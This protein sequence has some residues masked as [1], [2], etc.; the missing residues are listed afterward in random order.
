MIGD[1]V[2]FIKNKKYDNIFYS[3][4]LFEN[5]NILELLYIFI[6]N[7]STKFNE[8]IKEHIKGKGFINYIINRQLQYKVSSEFLKLKDENSVIGNY[9]VCKSISIDHNL[10]NKIET[11]NALDKFKDIYI[12]YN[13][14][15]SNLF[16]LKD[17][18]ITI[19]NINEIDQ[20]N[21]I[22][23]LIVEAELLIHYKELLLFKQIETLL[24]I[25]NKEQYDLHEKHL[26]EQLLNYH[27]FKSIS[28]DIKHNFFILKQK[29]INSYLNKTTLSFICEDLLLKINNDEDYKK[30]LNKKEKFLFFINNNEYFVYNPKHQKLYNALLLENNNYEFILKEYEF[31]T[32]FK[33]IILI[34]K[35][36]YKMEKSRKDSIKKKIFLNDGLNISKYYLIN[37]NW[38]KAYKNLFEYDSIIEY[39]EINEKTLL[40]L[41]KNKDYTNY[42]KNPK[43]LSPDYD[44]NY[45]DTMN[46]PINFELV[47]KDIFESIIEDINKRNK[48]NLKSNLYYNVMLG[49]NKIFVQDNFNETLFFI[50]SL[51]SDKYDLEYII[52]L[53]NRNLFNFINDNND[54]QSFEELLS[55]YGIDLTEKNQQ[56]L[57]DENLKEIGILINIKPKKSNALRGPSHCL[58]LE[59]IGA[60]CYMNATIQCLCHI[61]NMKNYFQNRKLVFNDINNKKCPLTKEFYKLIN[62]LWKYSFNGRKYFTPTNFKNIISQLNP[63]FEG[64]A[65]N[66]SKDLIIFIY[67]TMHNEINRQI[68]FEEVNSYNIDKD[69]LL[70]RKNY[71]SKNS[72]FLI[73]TFYFE[74]QSEINCLSCNFSKISYNISNILI[75]PL[76]KVREYIAKINTEG[77]ASVTLENCF[78][79]YQAKEML[80]GENQ[81]Y[82]NNC[83]KLSN[84]T[85]GNKIFTSPEVLT[86]ILNRGKGLEFDVNFEYPLY[87]DIDIFVIDKSEINNKYELIC[88]LTHLGPSG[89]AGHFIAF[90]KSPVDQKWYCYNDAS[91]SQ[92]GDPRYQ[93]NDEI[94]GIPYVLF[95]QKINSNKET[96]SKMRNI[97]E[98]YY[99][100]DKQNLNKF[101]NVKNKDKHSINLNFIYNEKEFN[102]SIKTYLIT[103]ANL[104]NKLCQEHD[105]IPYNSSLFIQIGENMYNIEDYLE[106]N[107]LK[108]GDKIIVISNDTNK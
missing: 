7:D 78:E 85:T 63:L 95:Y 30:F 6:Y 100:Y 41:F 20:N 60:T 101:Y 79:N 38:M 108:D 71:Y 48:I 33:N 96:I 75:F 37:K 70:F 19:S 99:D 62:S 107:K 72:S 23:I 15:I 8:E 16:N 12:Y 4:L 73:K 93:N 88:V 106:N 42:L 34:L 17:N 31:N 5:K 43:N 56:N 13:K 35:L 102:L 86:I 66:D 94:E 50:Y 87:L 39:N 54:K 52:I 14:F 104:I 46:V 76:E 74:Q 67:E 26:L 55:E 61:L 49:D 21:C 51:G 32:E 40:S 90:C 2:L 58:G 59:N 84:A 27:D 28:D 97:N 10:I 53:D 80:I 47:E 22:S 105:V 91:V 68:H 57:L 25:K 3:Y 29:E 81:I 18:K 98:I 1:N 44:N 64:I 45:S 11:Q 36:L 82:C 83:Q 103:P 24:K 9:K 65:A 69:L 89:M 77:F 92:C